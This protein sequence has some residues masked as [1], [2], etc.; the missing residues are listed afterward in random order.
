MKHN[1]NLKFEDIIEEVA[2]VYPR[3]MKTG[4]MEAGV[5]L[6]PRNVGGWKTV[7]KSEMHAS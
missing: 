6:K 3:I 2:G 7:P 5:P 1:G 4:D